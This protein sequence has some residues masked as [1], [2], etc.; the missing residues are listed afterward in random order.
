MNNICEGYHSYLVIAN[1]T[2]KMNVYTLILCLFLES[3]DIPAIIE[4]FCYVKPP[5]AKSKARQKDDYLINLWYKLDSGTLTAD[6]FLSRLSFLPKILPN[7][8]Y[9][10]RDSRAH[11]D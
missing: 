8:Q 1:F 3:E 11:L 10:K 9:A 6:T 7:G 4:S 2:T 5:N